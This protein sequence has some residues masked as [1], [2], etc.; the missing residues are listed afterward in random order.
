MNFAI[1]GGYGGLAVVETITIPSPDDPVNPSEE[2]PEP[3]GARGSG[4]LISG[5]LALRGPG[6]AFGD[7]NNEIE[8]STGG[9]SGY[10]GGFDTA[11]GGASGI[12]NEDL[13]VR[14]TGVEIDGNR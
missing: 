6:V 11:G 7:W 9:N 2:V 3:D 14:M 10:E 13:G 5:H 1:G 8:V 4:A 12:A